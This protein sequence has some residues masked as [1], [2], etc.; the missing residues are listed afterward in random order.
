M[1]FYFINLNKKT[2]YFLLFILLVGDFRLD[3]HK[4]RYK[5]YKRLKKDYIK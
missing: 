3:N 1:I 2:Y 5:Y 4:N